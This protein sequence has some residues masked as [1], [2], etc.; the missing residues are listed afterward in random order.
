MRSFDLN[1][2]IAALIY[3]E[4]FARRLLQVFQNDLSKSRLVVHEEWK[5]RKRVSRYKE[6]LARILGPLY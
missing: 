1:F 6:S 4:E 3:D 5:S 2:E